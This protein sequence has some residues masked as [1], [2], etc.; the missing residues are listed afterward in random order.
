MESKE[1]HSGQRENCAHQGNTYIQKLTQSEAVKKHKT[2]VEIK[3]QKLRAS[4]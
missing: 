2:S 1:K 4:I 3:V